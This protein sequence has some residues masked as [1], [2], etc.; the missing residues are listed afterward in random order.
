MKHIIIIALSLLSLYSCSLDE[1]MYD[2]LTPGNALVTPQDFS[3]LIGGTYSVLYGPEMYKEQLHS[4]LTAGADNFYTVSGG[5]K[6]SISTLS[7]ASSQ[8][9]FDYVWK[10]FYKIINNANNVIDRVDD[11]N[12]TPTQ[13]NNILGQGLFLRGFSYLNL[14]RLFGGVPLY[15]KPT[16]SATNFWQGRANIDELYQLLIT[17]FKQASY[18]LP[19][20]SQQALAEQGRGNSGGAQAYCALA[21]LTYGNYLAQNNRTNEAKLQFDIAKLYADS[22]INSGEYRLLDDFA[23]M[24]DCSKEAESYKEVIFALRFTIDGQVSGNTSK[25]SKLAHFFGPAN[26]GNIAANLNAWKGGWGH[27]KV[28]PWFYNFYTTGVYQGDYRAEV[29][30][31]TKFMYQLT[32]KVVITYPL[33]S[34][35]PSAVQSVENMPYFKKYEGKGSLNQN[36]ENNLPLMRLAEVYLIKAEA[37]NELNGPTTEALSAFNKLRE[38]ARK[39]NGTA[40]LTPSDL[41]LDQVVEKD[42]MRMAIFNERGAELAGEGHRWFDLVRMRAADG[43]SM[44]QYMNEYVKANYTAG[45]PKWSNNTWIT[46]VVGTGGM[47]VAN[48]YPDYNVRY[49]LFPIPSNETSLNQN[50]LPNNPGW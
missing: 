18:L 6:V 46:N 1:P 45:F 43:R 35:A 25:G 21:A 3:F 32:S 11:V 8:A 44:Y 9:E 37:E 4:I 47:Y 49:L 28:Q 5:S 23:T 20:A 17:D 16:T 26:E 24:F 27:Y 29:S 42:G 39:A 7:Y 15:E 12:L 38:R 10:G 13:Y 50:L 31:K 36:D 48:N 2:T 19:K 14:V 33:T 34:G 41:R 40:R 22:V 30:Y